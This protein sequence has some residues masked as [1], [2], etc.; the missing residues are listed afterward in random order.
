MDL[1]AF[2]RTTDRAAALAATLC[3][4]AVVPAGAVS[5][6]VATPAAA[7]L[8]QDVPEYEPL[9]DADPAVGRIEIPQ[10][11]VSSVILEGVDYKTIRRAVGHF[12][13][14]PLP[15]ESG[16]MAL[17]AH[18]TTDF[19]GLRHIRLGDE[20][21]VT[22]P[23]GAFRYRVESTRIVDPHDVWVL[24]PSN[25]KALTLVTCFPFDYPGS[26]PQRF[27]VR[28]RAVPREPAPA[29]PEVASG[30]GG[31]VAVAAA[32]PPPAAPGATPPAA[33]Q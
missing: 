19:Y 31:P 30:A 7:P 16:N 24:D 18:R 28:A 1:A 15:H 3:L 25:E 14:T 13:T 4:L 5:P 12:P 9:S 10:V 33:V 6:P 29:D 26:A 32:A 20:I 27:I 17:A 11:G 21:T 8:E 22:S 2:L 23:G